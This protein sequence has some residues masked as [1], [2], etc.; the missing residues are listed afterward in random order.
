MGCFHINH[1]FWVSPWLWKPPHFSAAG[2]HQSSSHVLRFGRGIRFGIQQFAQH[3]R[4]ASEGS[5]KPGRCAGSLGKP[6][7]LSWVSGQHLLKHTKTMHS[8]LVFP[9]N[10]WESTGIYCFDHE[11]YCR[12]SGIFFTWTSS[13]MCSWGCHHL[14]WDSLGFTNKKYQKKDQVDIFFYAK[15][16]NHCIGLVEKVLPKKWNWS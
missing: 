16:E 1:P 3:R 15:Q 9:E 10:G 11:I 5:R 6:Q 13:R 14:D 8:G 2:H 12:V 4:I 7:D